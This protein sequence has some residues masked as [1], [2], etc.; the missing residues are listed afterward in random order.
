MLPNFKKPISAW[1]QKGLRWHLRRLLGCA[2]IFS[3]GHLLI[4]KEKVCTGENNG[5]LGS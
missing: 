1:D 4:K 2:C 5:M 3:A